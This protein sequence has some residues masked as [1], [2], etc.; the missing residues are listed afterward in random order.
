[1][2]SRSLASASARVGLQ[3]A[4]RILPATVLAVVVLLWNVRHGL[5]RTAPSLAGLPARYYADVSIGTQLFLRG[6]YPV[7][8]YRVRRAAVNPQ[9]DEVFSRYVLELQQ[10][11]AGAGITAGRPFATIP[12][13]AD[14]ERFFVRRRDD[15]GRGVLLGLAFRALGGIAPY[16]IF[17]MAPILA[18]AV[19]CWIAFEA[20]AAG[21]ALAGQVLVLLLASSAY[22]TD[23]LALTYSPA[24][25]YLVGVMALAAYA[26]YA[27]RPDASPA[28]VLQ[29]T[30]AA[31][32][33][34]A[35]CALCRSGTL[36]LV[37]FFLGA[38]IPAL[39]RRQPWPSVLAK[40]AL[41]A[42]ILLGPYAA[43]ASITSAVAART[44]AAYSAP[45]EPQ[46]HDIWIS[47]WEGLGDFDRTHGY[48]WDDTDAQLQAGD[49][50]LGSL[51]SSEILRGQVFQGIR[52]DPSWYAGILLK[53]TVA[54]LSQWKL[55]PWGPLGGRSMRPRSH[56]NEGAIDSYY[57]LTANLDWFRIGRWLVEVPVPVFWIAVVAVFVLTFRRPSPES[58]AAAL[59]LGLVLVAT[60]ALPVA[61]TTAG[62][63]ETQAIAVAYF[64]ALAL[65][66]GLGLRGRRI[67]P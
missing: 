65:L 7:A 25:F 15:S 18:A 51:R 58:R 13:P 9:G 63:L 10:A 56:Y 5:D 16:L 60:L 47:V 43:A 28:G 4:V 36:V 45:A 3:C 55:L 48:V 33:V 38:A 57:A 32:A 23:L 42:A 24:G 54:T 2:A 27:C 66:A 14:E 59:V 8:S 17:W 1:M 26:F 6:E 40:A 21:W 20:A 12:A 53:R 44:A 67:I 35:V 29:R 41:A 37:P 39:R 61:I 64:L 11:A 52:N 19:L 22:V 50:R 49:W 34:V 62:A 30:A 31:A 46:D